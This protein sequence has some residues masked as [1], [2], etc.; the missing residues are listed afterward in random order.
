MGKPLTA[1][2]VATRLEDRGVIMLGD[3][4]SS[5]SRALF[6]CP[7]C[8]LEWYSITNSVFQGHG[9][10]DC[11]RKRGI[12]SKIKPCVAEKHCSGC[13]E[14]KAISEFN[15]SS[16]VSSGYR[17]RCREC[18][19]QNY[20]DNWEARNASS[21]A[22]AAANRDRVN[23]A[24]AAYLERNREKVL[25]NARGVYALNTNGARDK[26][27]AYRA[28]HKEEARDY[29]KAYRGDHLDILRDRAI[30]YRADNREALNAKTRVR[31]ARRRAEDPR[32]RMMCLLRRRM[33]HALMGENKSAHTEELLGCTVA[34]Y[35]EYLEEFFYGEYEHFNL[36]DRGLW[37]VHHVRP[38]HTF[39]LTDPAQQRECFN[40]KNTIPL[41][42]GD[43]KFVHSIKGQYYG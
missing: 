1:E 21:V 40:Y 27:E 26:I 7:V 9:C 41:S 29:N 30:E 14:L 36:D 24:S 22:W 35:L 16:S 23:A 28:A 17:A 25:S 8:D 11:G 33:H 18:Q 32:Y 37:H 13:G 39:D 6:R 20:C 42:I 2:E 38:C 15:K 31:N 3:Y 34:K 5:E 10:P 43:H 12:K 19:K 4:V